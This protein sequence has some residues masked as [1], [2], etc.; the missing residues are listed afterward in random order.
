M[1]FFDVYTTRP[2]EELEPKQFR[3]LLKGK[4]ISISPHAL[5][6]LSNNQR[7]L[8]KPEEIIMRVQKENPRRVFLQ[9]NGR[10]A[11]YYRCKQDFQKIIMDIISEDAIIITFMNVAV[12]PDIASKNGN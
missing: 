9:W 10:Y 5:D 7:K 2:V 12:L 8:F 11:A 1:A 6:H 3:L 4:R